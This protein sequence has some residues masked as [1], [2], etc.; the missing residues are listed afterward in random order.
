[1]ANAGFN[2]FM[3]SITKNKNKNKNNTEGVAKAAPPTTDVPSTERIKYPGS[4]RERIT[5]PF[6]L[7]TND[8]QIDSLNLIELQA[9]DDLESSTR[10]RSAYRQRRRALAKV[11]SEEETLKLLDRRRINRTA[12][13]TRRRE[14][15]GKIMAESE[16]VGEMTTGEVGNTEVH[17]NLLDSTGEQ[18]DMVSAGVDPS[19]VHDGG[20][21]QLPLDAFFERP[22]SIYDSSWPTGT[23]QDVILDPWN[24]WS[25]D[26]SVRAKLSN[27]AYFRATLHVKVSVT[28]TPYHFGR[29]MA[30]YQP[31]GN[32]NDTLIQYDFIKTVTTPTTAQIRPLYK[33]YLSQAPGVGYIDI[34]ENEPLEMTIPFISKSP[35]F[36]LF[37]DSPSVITNSTDF[38]DFLEAGQLRLVTLNTPEIANDDFDSEVSVNVYAWMTGVELGSITSTDINITAQSAVIT[39]ESESKVS[40]LYTEEGSLG[41]RLWKSIE[42]GPDE[43]S[44]PGPI[45]K[46]A[47]ALSASAS[48]MSMAPYIGPFAK[49]TA[50]ASGGLA[51]VASMFGWSRPAVLADPTFVKNVP[52]QNGAFTSGKETTYKL[53]ADPKQE[54]SIDQ[55]LGGHVDDHMTFAAVAGRE[56]FLTTFTW[57]DDDTALSTVLWKSLVT[58]FLYSSVTYSLGGIPRGIVQPTAMDFTA[59]PF[60]AWRGK[61]RFRF[62]VVCSRFHR[63]KIMFKYEPNI[64]QHA[65]ITSNNAKLNQQNSVILDIQEAQDITI[66]VDWAMRNNWG[67]APIIHRPSEPNC[68]LPNLPAE[69]DGFRS[70]FY[71]NG[72]IQV[73]VLNELVQPTPTSGV[74]VN[75][76]VS[77]PDLEL[78]RMSSMELPV[79]RILNSESEIITINDTCSK[80]T[81]AIFLDHFGERLVSFRSLLKRYTT[82]GY[83]FKNLSITGPAHLSLQGTLYPETALRQNA[84]PPNSVN[85]T[86][87]FQYLRAAY[88]GIRGGMRYRI[89]QFT[90][91]QIGNAD[92]VRCSLGFHSETIDTALAAD[93]DLVNGITDLPILGG[94]LD[95]SVLSHLA[96]NGGVEFEVPFYS[97]ALFLYSFNS[98][99]IPLD[100]T[101]PQPAT[102][103][104]WEALFG[105]TVASGDSAAFTVDSATAEDFTFLRFQGSP[106]YGQ[107]AGGV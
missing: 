39:S 59:T 38:T 48:I 33:T 37:N 21:T 52:F 95:G 54:L 24:L 83:A 75:V 64:P 93:A 36:R 87:L 60:A 10:T 46:W 74:S 17:G 13:V 44:E 94:R 103:W 3:D 56:S 20:N 57:D 97:H 65:L 61:I 63:G 86:T 16:I 81:P 98:N 6:V 99:W 76:F 91:A 101:D 31:F 107:S 22:V 88:M 5:V 92:Y 34:K 89:T 23:E 32:F 80:V 79:T 77:C 68:D 53:T 49:A 96:T 26:A 102:S 1:M 82:S 41:S 2:L 70:D 11:E 4:F 62:E 55:R 40:P 72:N 28:G 67:E 15:R 25:R 100:E 12:R 90:N 43:Y 106:P 27:Y 7:K 14:T 84:A 47:S 42:A 19:P 78:N 29:V 8:V 71:S 18:P 35:K 73:R 105:A 69:F 85:A 104:F 30:S 58:P 50:T 45:T 66:E 9:R 51:A